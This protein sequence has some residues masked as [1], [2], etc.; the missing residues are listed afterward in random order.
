M[1]IESTRF[2]SLDVNDT[3]IIKFPQ[4][5]SGFPEEKSFVLIAHQTDSPFAFLQSATEPNLTFVMLE[6]L[7]ISKEYEFTLSDQIVEELNLSTDNPPQIFNIVTTPEKV[8]DMTV[9]LL[10]PIVM[11]AQ[12]CTAQQV[13][14][15]NVSYTTRHRIFIEGLSKMMK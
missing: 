14:L 12:E 5:L 2:G 13:V 8:D 7:S 4:G 15:E 11:N 9:N 3:N 1:I 6:T 10:A